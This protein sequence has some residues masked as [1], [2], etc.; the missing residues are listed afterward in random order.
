MPSAGSKTPEFFFSQAL[1]NQPS[2]DKFTFLSQRSTDRWF[3]NEYNRLFPRCARSTSAPSCFSQIDKKFVIAFTPRVGS[4]LLCQHLFRYGVF[5]AEFLNPIHLEAETH[6]KKPTDYYDL[7]SKLIDRYAVNGVFGL[8]AHV[9]ATVPLFEAQEF[10]SHIPDWRFVYITRDNIVR[11]AV[12][13]VIAELRDSWASWI[14]PAREVT[15]ADYSAHRIA[16]AIWSTRLSQESWEKF[17][18]LFN[19]EPLRITYE[20]IIADPREA[21]A[22]VARHCDLQLGGQELVEQFDDPPLLPQTT[23][24]NSEWERRFRN[25]HFCGAQPK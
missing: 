2:L 5:V 23:L 22:R 17:F 9:Q 25:E 18:H 16:R 21:A 6:V 20:K 19:I 14:E 13:Q 4:T 8:K 10:P 7:F 3:I 1:Q 24:L 11:Q 12:S 15:D